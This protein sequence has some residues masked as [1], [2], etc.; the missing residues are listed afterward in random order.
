MKTEMS[1]EIGELTKALI[2]VQ[3]DLQPVKKN[4]KGQYAYADIGAVA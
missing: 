1:A 4:A 2:I 3:Q